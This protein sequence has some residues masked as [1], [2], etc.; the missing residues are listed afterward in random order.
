VQ[1]VWRNFILSNSINDLKSHDTTVTRL[2]LIL[3]KLDENEKPTQSELASEFGVS[4]RTIQ[5]DIGR[6]CYFPIEKTDDGKLYF[7]EGFS[8][9]RTSFQEIEMVLMSLSLSMIMEVSP[10]FSKTAHSLLSKLLIPNYSTPYLIKQDPFESIDMDSKNINEL[11]FAIKNKRNTS[12]AIDKKIYSVEPYKIVSFDEIWYLFAKDIDS[13]KIKTFF[14]S[15]IKEVDYSIKT[16]KLKKSIDSILENVHT[17]W[18]E[19]GV[20]FEVKIKVMQPIAHYFK[21]KKHLVSQEILKEHTDG[22]LEISF[23]VSSDE[24]VDNVIKAWLPHIVI[25]SPKRMK[26]KIQIELKEY[27]KL[28]EI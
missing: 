17:A 19:Y 5:R 18:F 9:K 27:L 16:F 1:H 22:S 7:T 28:L 8:L 20:Q 12:I 25:I 24:E 11:E 2:I 6:L 14:I 4:L 15:D 13:N 26:D 10:N 23:Q 21:R 3:S